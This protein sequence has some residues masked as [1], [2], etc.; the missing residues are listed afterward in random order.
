MED[1]LFSIEGERRMKDYLKAHNWYYYM[2]KRFTSLI[3]ISSIAGIILYVIE[4]IPFVITSLLLI[5]NL[6]SLFTFGKYMVYKNVKNT[7]EVKE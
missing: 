6:V 3:L 4:V 5:I 2:C 1:A 7:I